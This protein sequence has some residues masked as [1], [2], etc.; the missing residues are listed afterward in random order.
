MGIRLN[1]PPMAVRCDAVSDAT[2]WAT[3]TGYQPDLIHAF[4]NSNSW[5]GV[6]TSTATQTAL[7]PGRKLVWAVPLAT[8]TNGSSGSPPTQTTTPAQFAA[9]TYDVEFNLMLDRILAHN[10]TGPIYIRPGWEA[11]NFSAFP[12]GATTSIANARTDY[13][14]AFQ[15]A[16]TL[17]RAKSNRFIISWCPA[18][19]NFDFTS[20]EVNPFDAVTGFD[21]GVAYYDAVGVDAYMIGFDVAN[22]QTFNR[23]SYLTGNPALGFN[24]VDHGFRDFVAHARTNDLAMTIDEWAVGADRPDYIQDMK[25]FI[26]DPL[27]RVLYHGFWNKNA[28]AGAAPYTFPCRLSDNSNNYPKTKAAFLRE[29][30]GT[31]T[32]VTEQT[33]TAAYFPRASSTPTDARRAAVDTLV[34][35]LKAGGLIP[36]LDALFILAGS[37]SEIT[38]INLLGSGAF[39]PWISG[40]TYGRAVGRA[41]VVGSPVFTADRGWTG[42][43]TTTDGLRLQGSNPTTAL[44]RKLAQNDAHFGIWSRTAISNAGAQTFE[45]GNANTFIGRNNTGT[46]WIARPNAAG[47][48]T[49]G[50]TGQ[51]AG[52]IMFNRTSA[53][54]YQGYFNGV[55]N[56]RNQALQAS[57]SAALTNNDFRIGFV[58]TVGGGVNQLAFMHYGR[59]LPTTAFNGPLALY[60]ALLA[61]AT[62][63]GA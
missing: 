28:P 41:D 12:W 63:V 23:F 42:I 4:T 7:F 45:A 26:A 43:G 59:A 2:E 3:W 6:L 51:N 1:L 10:P 50:D 18:L 62:A 36:Y 20:A 33:E 60:N 40:A 17:I 5:S 32:R 16:S 49:I 31:G 24:D 22:G 34:A 58:D 37:E 55:A 29:F 11:G 48:I 38:R 54:D 27:N 15:K 46:N 44:N 9:G 13:I 19:I 61:Y 52:H 53:T 47:T 30:Y 8:G 56:T 57:A 39:Q 14:A 35:S 21:P 25:A